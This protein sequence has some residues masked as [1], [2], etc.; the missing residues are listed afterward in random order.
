VTE[1]RAFLG[2]TG[3]YQ[4]FIPNYSRIT[5]PLLDLT[6]KTT[7]WLWGDTQTNAFKLLKTLMCRRPILAQPDYTKPFILYTDTSGYGVGA[8]LLQEGDPNPEHPLKFCLHPIAYYSATF[9]P[10]EWNYD[11]YEQELLAVV[12]AL[13]HWRQHL[14]FTRHPFTVVTDHANLAFWKE[15]RDLNRHTA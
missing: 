8:I 14:G 12:K 2:F 6:K 1:V 15:P 13:K 7:P 9:I 5:Q 10:A 3:F 11:I 4:Y